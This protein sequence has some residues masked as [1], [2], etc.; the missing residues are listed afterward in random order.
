MDSMVGYVVTY[1]VGFIWILDEFNGRRKNVCPSSSQ[2][3]YVSHTVRPAFTL[4]REYE[5]RIIHLDGLCVSSIKNGH[6]CK[7]EGHTGC[8]I[9][10]L[11]FYT[12]I[13]QSERY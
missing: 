8:V 1:F 13:S 3:N 6:S 9:R 10:Q 12:P 4:D 11:D 7:I 5:R 2:T